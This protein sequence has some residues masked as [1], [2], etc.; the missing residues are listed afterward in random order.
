MPPADEQAVLIHVITPAEADGSQLD[1]VEEPLME[2]LGSAGVG[3]YDGH[4]IGPGEV[5]LYCYGSDADRLLEAIQPV[6]LRTALP[7]GSYA[8]K[9]YGPPGAASKR[10]DLAEP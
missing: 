3:E 5:T 1:A 9:R 10:V 2:A 6:L 7:R 4:E 8:V